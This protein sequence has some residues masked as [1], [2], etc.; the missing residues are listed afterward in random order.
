VIVSTFLKRKRVESLKPLA[1]WPVDRAEHLRGAVNA[2][3]KLNKGRFDDRGA[4]L[5]PLA[6]GETLG[7]ELIAVEP[8]AR[9]ELLSEAS[10]RDRFR[11]MLL[12]PGER[13]LPPFVELVGL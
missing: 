2:R 5:R 10:E 1:A 7:V 6:G 4:F 3:V 12:D 13:A 8:K 9:R 11:E